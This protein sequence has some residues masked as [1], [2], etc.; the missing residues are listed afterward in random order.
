MTGRFSPIVLGTDGSDSAARALDHAAALATRLEAEIVVVHAHP[1]PEPGG[2]GPAASLGRSLLR[3]AVSHCG[4]NVRVRTLLREGDPADVLCAVAAEEGAGLLV[5]GNRGMGKRLAVGN[6]PGKVAHRAPATM[7]I[8]QTMREVLP[9]SVRTLVATD[10]SPTA[11]RAV[12]EGLALAGAVGAEVLLLH[13]GDP[14]RGAA[15]LA[16]AAPPG[17][18]TRTV[19]GDPAR[20]IV[21]VAE[22]ERCDL[23]VV[24]NRG[25]QGVRRFL[26]SVPGRVARKAPGHLLLVKTS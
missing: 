18:A 3:D 26:G 12:A 23:I 1:R 19:E 4:E 24:G 8:A 5:V 15:V 25:M 2:T 22:E 14:G 20:R 7:L 21:E 9:P 13:V 16:E 6:V 10:G 11:A 17:V